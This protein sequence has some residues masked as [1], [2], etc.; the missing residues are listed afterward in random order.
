MKGRERRKIL[1]KGFH[2]GKF[3]TL[4]GRRKPAMMTV[5]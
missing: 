1:L 4:P 2:R 5:N 3:S